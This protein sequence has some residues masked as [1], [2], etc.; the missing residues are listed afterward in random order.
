MS[1]RRKRAPPVRVDE[2]SKKRLEWNMLEDRKNESI[3]EEDQTPTCSVLPVDPFTSSFFLPTPGEAAGTTSVPFT[4]ELPS[5]SS[6]ATS[7][8]AT[9][10]LT[11]EAASKLAHVWKAK[12]GEFSVQPAWMPSDCQ[13][14]AFVLHR[15]G[16][17]LCV[18]YSS[19]DD[20]A[21]LQWRPAEDTCTA[22][23]SLSAIPL[24]DL[25]WMQKR[26][27]VQLCHQERE[28]SVKVWRCPDS[29]DPSVQSGHICVSSPTVELETFVH[30]K[31]G[32]VAINKCVVMCLW[33][34]WDLCA[35]SWAGEA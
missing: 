17:Q 19:Y 34:G 13:Q 5:T 21:R 4:E 20:S 30:V 23:C 22:E 18:S 10:A 33:A 26:R 6:D 15:T 35:G 3:Q 8:S 28:G 2:E 32:N 16:D 27:V 1:S 24:E 14:R 7:A 11:V 9:L 31:T 29:G 25:D 12:I